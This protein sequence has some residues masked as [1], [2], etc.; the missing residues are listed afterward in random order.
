MGSIEKQQD[1]R[2]HGIDF[3]TILTG[4]KNYDEIQDA[5]GKTFSDMKER[6]NERVG[7]VS[8]SLGNKGRSMKEDMEL[9]RKYTAKLHQEY[10]FPVFSSADIFSTV[11]RDLKETKLTQEERSS[12]MKQ[13]FRGILKNGV[14]DI[15]MMP[16]WR[17]AEGATDEFETARQ[18]GIKIHDLDTSIYEID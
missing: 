2:Q 12:R 18:I 1:L 17:E 14:T 6:G 9:M 15:F 8:G 16:D 11:W 7:F 5:I 10:G 3:A 13:L 4:V